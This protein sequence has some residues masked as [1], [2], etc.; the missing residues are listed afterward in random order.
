VVVDGDG[1]GDDLPTELG[2]HGDNSSEEVGR[3]FVIALVD[4]REDK[5]SVDDGSALHG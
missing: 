5:E 3:L 1:D 4:D 2:E